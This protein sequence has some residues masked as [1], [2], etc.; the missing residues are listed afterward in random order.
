MIQCASYDATLID[1]KQTSI[2]S[3]IDSQD[4]MLIR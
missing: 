1:S 2:K 4:V 3:N